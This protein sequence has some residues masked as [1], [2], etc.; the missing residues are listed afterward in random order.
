MDHLL[1]KVKRK[2]TLFNVLSEDAIYNIPDLN[3]S[4]DYNPSTTLDEGEWYRITELSEREFNLPFLQE[5][6]VSGEY[7]QIAE[8]DY[9][10]IDYLCSVQEEGEY[11][12][13]QKLFSGQLIKKHWLNF[14][15]Q[16]TIQ[17][18][19]PVIILNQ[20]P[21]AIYDKEEDVLYFKKLPPLK[22]IFR[23][24]D[25][26]YREA[27]DDETQTF[28]DND[29]ITLADGFNAAAVKIPNRKRIAM[30]LDTLNGYS[31]RKKR[32]IFRYISQYCDDIQFE[33]NSFTISSD[34]HLKKLL[35]G[36]DERFYTTNTSKEKRIANS[37]IPIPPAP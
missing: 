37:V 13:F 18:E 12:C 17:K 29:F 4:V 24:I 11:Y 5:D 8:N 3:D 9:I 7:N 10:K 33:N 35:Y 36:I 22:T 26:L 14:S 34:E 15:N 21:D 23:G 19:K 30:V 2:I 27:T 31:T 25:T 6:F 1:A 32:S 20:V 16:P 28:L